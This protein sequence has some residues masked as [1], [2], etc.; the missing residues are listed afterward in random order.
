MR[1]VLQVVGLALLVAGC[2][3]GVESSAGTEP[4]QITVAPGEVKTEIVGASPQQRQILLASL[5]G[6]RDRRIQTITVET[7]DVEWGVPGGVGVRFAPRP[8]AADDMRM[9]WEAD[10]VG[11]AFADRSRE[12]GLPP[13]AY[14]A[15]PDGE[16]GIGSI[17]DDAR[18]R[19]E[20]RVQAFA[21]RIATEAGR[22]DA[23]VTDVE[24]L[25]PLQYAV[26]VT[27]QVRDPA[28]FL[29]R[30]ALPMF[31][32]LG[33]P[34]RDYDLRIVD[35][36][37]GRVSENWNAGSGGAVW[38]RKDLEGCSPYRVSRPVTYEP[39]ICPD[40]SPSKQ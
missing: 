7:A 19:S 13:V 34:P 20:E 16:S 18:R 28:A 14:I 9:S 40:Q 33:E 29:D 8:E 27:L 36:S 30:R 3:A 25:K 2:G 12:V 5:A 39:P 17:S 10:L 1:V 31:Q 35:P 37:G 22:A 21:R 11:D 23:T 4:R 32:R 26:A 24:V 15:A 6:V 38:V